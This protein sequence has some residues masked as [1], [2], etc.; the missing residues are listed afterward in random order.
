ML[1]SILAIVAGFVAIGVLSFGTA[2]GLSAAGI[3]P[4]TSQPTTDTGVL[5]LTLAYVAVYAIAGCYLTAVLAPNR[6]MRHALILGAL[7]LVFNVVS[8]LGMRGLFP[9]WY[10]A[11]GVLTTMPYAWIGGRLRELQLARG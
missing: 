5:L 8:S 6:P 1:R 11:V 10:L 3:L 4:D 9:D 2:A 7:G